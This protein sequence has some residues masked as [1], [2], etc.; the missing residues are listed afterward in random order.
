MSY[1]HGLHMHV[2]MD[3][4]AVLA[5]GECCLGTLTPQVTAVHDGFLTVANKAG[6]TQDIPFGACV[7]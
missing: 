2:N 7:W 5:W 4:L 1:T 6:E 3:I